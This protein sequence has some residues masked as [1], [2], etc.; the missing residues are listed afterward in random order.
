MEPNL[1]GIAS[2]IEAELRTIG[3]YV[4]RGVWMS[5]NQ[6]RK[7]PDG[8]SESPEAEEPEPPTALVL[9]CLLGDVAFTSRVQNAQQYDM[10]QE[11]AL[12]RRDFEEQD[13]EARREAMRQALAEGRDPFDE[14]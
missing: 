4:D 8:D 6:A 5:P 14:G 13:F 12:L 3:V 11:F 10:D 7:G 9:E 2:D 1:Q